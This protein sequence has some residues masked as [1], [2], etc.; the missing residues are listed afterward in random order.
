MKLT[1]FHISENLTFH[2]LLAIS[3]HY[4]FAWKASGSEFEEMFVGVGARRIRDL[5]Q[6]VGFLSFFGGETWVT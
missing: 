2:F 5:F 6:E 1:L 4:C 3:S